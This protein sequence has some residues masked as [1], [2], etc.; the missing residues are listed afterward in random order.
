[1]T[2]GRRFWL[3]LLAGGTLVWAVAVAITAATR[4]PILAPTVILVGS[5]LVPATMVAFALSRAGVRPLEAEAVVLGFVVAGSLGVV[6]SALV[7]TYALPSSY[8]TFLGVGLIEELTKG[9]VV[10]GVALLVVRSREPRHGLIL[11]ATV[12][13]GFAAFESA[14]YALMAVIGHS[15]D[16]PVRRIVETEAFRAMLAPFGHITWT[17]LL[18]GA[19]FAASSNGAFR[20]R[21]AVIA[22]LVGIVGLHA[23]WDAS[24]GGAIMLTNGLTGAGWSLGWPN[25]QAWIGEPTGATLAVFQAVYDVLVGLCAVLGAAW[26]VRRWRAT[27]AVALAPVRSA[28]V[29]G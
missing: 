3:W 25:T 16:H 9:A 22:T 19:L 7:E 12:G 28:A 10:V 29:A 20:A 1:M 27:R 11:G 18:G 24:Y 8:G 5:F 23:A 4:D 6:L 26:V 2:V 21:P 13:A 15:D 14:G 17:A